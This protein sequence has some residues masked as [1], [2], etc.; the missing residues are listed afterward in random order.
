[1]RESMH[2]QPEDPYGVA[3]Y[4]VELD[5]KCAH[6]MFGL[7]YIIFRPHNVYGEYQNIGDRYRNVVG[8][9]MNQLV[10]GQDLT[11][12]GDGEQTRAFSYIDDVAPIIARSVTTKG[13]YNQV[14]NIGADQEHSVN[15][16]ASAVMQAMKSDGKLVHL[17]P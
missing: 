14:F 1:M 10:Q 5:L 11:V 12:F 15:E 3:K 16:L 7:D 17:P 8:I 9:F 6:E 4:A 2:P 13:A